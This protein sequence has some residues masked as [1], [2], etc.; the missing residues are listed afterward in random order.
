VAKQAGF[1][2]IEIAIVL[3]IMG[4]LL[5]GVLRAQEFITSAR[6]R[7]L[8]AQ[9][10][11]IKGAYFG[12]I[13][14]YRSLPGDYATATTTIANAT[15]N[16]DGN[17]QVQMNNGAVNEH[18]LVWEH[19][20]RAEFISGTYSYAAA[21]T[22][23]S[24]PRNP[25][26]AFMQLVFDANYGPAG[27]ATNRHN[28]KTGSAIPV[29]ILAEIDRK[30]DDGLPGSGTFLSSG[31]GAPAPAANCVNPAVGGANPRPA[32]WNAASNVSNC[33]GALLF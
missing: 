28:L 21:Q 30:V 4:L 12:F 19:L 33:S 20:S 3:V 1:T 6:V 9:Q 10:D 27:G 17:G 16:G 31:Y 32:T 8:I 5:G 7:N 2:L 29:E 13:D 25:Y 26:G 14:R 22:D 11:G 18:I 15:M 24:N 23:A